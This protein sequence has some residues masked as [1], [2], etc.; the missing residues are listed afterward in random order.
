MQNSI[1]NLSFIHLRCHSE[2]SIIDGIVKI[3]DY[4]NTAKKDAM[5]A[6]ALT[7]LS[8]VF[9]AIK[10]YK[11]ARKQGLKP[12]IGCDIW[13]ENENNRDKPTRAL[14]LVQSLGGYHLL[15]ELLSRA[16][17]E[18]QYRG[19]A[20]LKSVW[21][22]NGTEGLLMLSGNSQSDIGDAICQNNMQLAKTIT[23]KWSALFPNRF[24]IE[25]QRSTQQQLTDSQDSRS[26]EHLNQEQLLQQC[27]N[28]ATDLG[29]PVVATQPIQFVK[30]DDFKAHE[31]PSFAC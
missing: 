4:V 9:G 28:I 2:Y 21:F 17:L 12:I 27:L 20:E 18:N 25:L 6:L 31:A 15:C 3:N 14:L 24:Y 19:R 30:Q 7:D 1:D 5:P 26:K 29:L 16:Y 10:F 23:Q 8:N 11:A 13:L 22:E